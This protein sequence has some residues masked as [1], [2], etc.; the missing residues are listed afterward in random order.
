[1]LEVWF[2]GCHCGNALSR[3]RMPGTDVTVVQTL[4]G[5]RSRTAPG[6]AWPGFHFVG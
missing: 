5:D 2:A 1:V 6:I 4:V 3:C